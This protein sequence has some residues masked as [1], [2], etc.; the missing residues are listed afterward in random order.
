MNVSGAYFGISYSEASNAPYV[1]SNRKPLAYMWPQM[2]WQ[3]NAKRSTID[4][5]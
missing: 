3:V 5:G 2:Q 4:A 1:P